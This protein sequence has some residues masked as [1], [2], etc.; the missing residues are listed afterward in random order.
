MRATDLRP[1]RFSKGAQRGVAMAFVFVLIALLLLVAILVVTGALNAVNQ[2]EAVGVK[3]GVLNSAEAAANLALNE[4]AENPKMTPGCVTGTLNGA[5]YRSCM[6]LNN[7]KNALPQTATDYANGTQIIVPGGSAYIYG[8]ATNNGSRKTYVEAIARP[9]PPLNLPPGAVNAAQNINDLTPEPVH[10]DPLHANDA[11][12]YANNNIAVSSSPWSVVQGKTFA[13]GS[14]V[15]PGAD[16][17]THPG[18]SPVYF[19]T[20]TQVSQAAQTAKLIAQAGTTVSGS[21]VAGG[22][23]FTGDVYVNGNVNLSSG[24]VTFSD[25]ETVYV[26]GNLCINGTGELLNA[27]A[28]QGVVMVVGGVM[29]SS[30][31]GGYMTSMPT[32]ALLIVLGNDPGPGNPCGTGADALSLMPTAGVEPVGTVYAANGSVSVSGTGTVQGALDG[33]IN[34]DIAGS[35]AAAAIQYD[36]AQ[37]STTMTTGTMTYTAYNQD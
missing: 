3:Y 20:P 36:A 18:S 1:R 8:E 33:G 32:N 14:D 12:L 31:A 11:N 35:S 7:L 26:N 6:G 4:L 5:S 27:N 28:G 23:S 16:G 15:L 9:A 34:V 21:S 13:V 30:G 10:Q 25:G 29:S 19:P 24:T 22:Q 17:Q 2:A 37:A